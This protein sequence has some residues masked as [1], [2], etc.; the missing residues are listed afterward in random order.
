MATSGTV[1][2]Y[3]YNITKLLEHAFRRAGFVPEKVSG[4]GMFVARDLL[5]TLTSEMVNQS[6]P[7]WTQSYDLLSIT[8]GSADVY[9]PQGTLDVMSAYW[10]I[11]N[12]WRGPAVSAA[13]DVSALFG[14][15]PNP[16]VTI[17]GPQPYAQVNF[18]TPQP[19]DTVGVLLGG[20]A[21]VT[22][23]LALVTSNDGATFATSQTLPSTTFTP[24]VWSYFA[25][26]PVVTAQYLR[27][28]NP[29]SGSWTLN[30]LNFGLA[31]STDIELG[32]LSQQDYFNLPNKTFSGNQIVQCWVDRQLN[33]PILRSWPVPSQYAFYNGTMACFRRRNIQDP[34]S[35]TDTLEVPQRWIEAITWHLAARLVLE[36]P[37]EMGGLDQSGYS[38]IA[39]MQDKQARL[40]MCEQGAQRSDALA[41]SEER[42]QGPIRLTP[43]IAPYT[44]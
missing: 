38:A 24:G 43:S 37:P 1:S 5:F 31:S 7:L 30:Q 42:V 20:N 28:Q 16:D 9:T 10:R 34:G 8:Q 3:S 32:L 35:F 17:A 15:Q 26:S 33:V 23:A 13:G 4:E 6:V 25:L 39:K 19:V 36:I 29:G 41:W 12:P 40:Q 44:A 2:Q 27:L 21:P 14:G 18:S 11:L 22:A